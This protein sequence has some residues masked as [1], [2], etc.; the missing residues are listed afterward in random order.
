MNKKILITG[1]IA[2]AFTWA[3]CDSQLDVEPNNSIDANT[4]LQTSADVEALMVGAYDALGDIDVYGGNMHMAAELLGDDGELFWDGTYVA[5]GE[6]WSK[7]MLINNDQADVTWLDCYKTINICNTVLANLDLISEDRV[8]RIEG[9][10]KFIRG[11]VY[12]DLVRLYARTWTDGDPASN[13]GVPIVMTP[14]TVENADTKVARSSVAEIY[15]LVLD[16]L[17]A[18]ES[19]LPEFNGF[20]AT[21][22]AASAMLSRVYLMQNKYDSAA[23]TA[24]RVITSNLYRLTDA[25]AGAFNKGSQEGANATT[26]DIFAIQ[27]NSQDGTNDLN[28]FFAS[29][30][31]GGR[32]D[33]YVEPAHFDLYEP[34]DDRLNLFYDDERTGKWMNQFGNVNI[35]RLAEMYLTRAEANFREGSTIGEDPLDDVNFI[36]ARVNLGPLGAITLDDILLERHL[37][38]A[39][40]GH[41][42]HDLKRTQSNVGDL[43]F[44]APELV[45]PIPLREL[46]IYPDLGQNDGYN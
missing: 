40:E 27:I 3:A 21:T 2:V 15:N 35:I 34:G 18:A 46:N 11:S 38:L 43:T 1:L 10:A 26:E 32:G 12:F 39:F 19:L 25:Y 41:L 28:T 37:E 42:I 36:R 45:F 29:S 22:Y 23:E 4:A 14:T 13:P 33:I 30:D 16:D 6:I 9:E 7:S 20:F 5:P 8:D 24:N 17:T 44:D 31:F